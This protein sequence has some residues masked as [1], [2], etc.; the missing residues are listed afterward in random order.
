[1][2]YIN[3]LNIDFDQWDKINDNLFDEEYVLSKLNDED[4]NKYFSLK[5]FLLKNNIFNKFFKNIFKYSIKTTWYL[6]FIKDKQDN[7]NEIKVIY[8][9]KYT[10]L[11]I[12][13]FN[14]FGWGLTS[15]G[16]QYWVNINDNWQNFCKN[17]FPTDV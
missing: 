7:I 17:Q 3:K 14:S 5:K 12:L 16:F 8:F 2:K 10:Q 4:K 13:I 9:I 1:M 15:D 6:K 11:L